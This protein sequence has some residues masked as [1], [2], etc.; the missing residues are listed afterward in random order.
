MKYSRFFKVLAAAV[1]LSLLLLAIP[2]TPALGATFT[3]SASTGPTGTLI[4]VSGSGFITDGSGYVWFDTNDNSAR[5][6]GE[7]Y[8]AATITGGTLSAPGTMTVPTV[9]RGTHYVLV[10]VPYDTSPDASAP[11]VVT[12]DITITFTT[13]AHVGDTITVAGTGFAATAGIT[14]RFDTTSVGTTT[15]T[16]TGTFSSFTF[17]VPASTEGSHTIK[18]EETSATSNNDTVSIAISPKITINPTTG[19][20]GDAITVSGNGFD[21]SS[22]VTVSFDAVTMTTASTNSSGTLSSATFAVPSTSRGTHTVRAQDAGSNYA[23]ATFTVS[24]KITINPTSGPSGTTVTVT[25][26]GFAASQTV[27][28]T[29]AGTNVVTSPSTVTTGSTGGF[30]ATFVV[31]VSPVGTYIVSAGDGVNTAT[32]NFQST[33]D[34]TISTVTS[35]SA[36]GNV[37]MSLTITGVGFTPNHAIT[38]TFAG[39]QL[40]VTGDSATNASGNFE[41]S[42]I[43]PAKASGETYT[44]TVS[45]GTITKTFDFVMESNAPPTPAMTLPL[46]DTKLKDNL[47][48][49]EAVEDVSPASNPITYDLQVASDADFTTASSLLGKTE[50]TVATYTLL[51]EEKLESTSKDAPYYWRVRAVD[52]ASNASAW[53]EPVP[54]TT[55]WSFAFT[56]W[57]VWV[58]LVVVAIAF[59]FFGLWVGRRSGGGD[60]Y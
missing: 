12:P 53:S 20:V 48:E 57:V 22:T 32:A 17:T 28:I 15:T 49:W 33:T 36:P 43:V 31:P 47:F 7:P 39:T 13:P 26:T 35:V 54:F 5:D 10:A 52:A 44:I 8:L 25:G 16:A 51:D 55:G 23:T 41:C 4:T 45:D 50:L 14:V 42:F 58:T 6:S 9:A 34:A 60:F 27:I 21:G 18:A 19:S 56:G 30:T 40:T 2:V 29:Y 24:T 11:F 3:L 59:F 37:G 1:V 38:V 46:A